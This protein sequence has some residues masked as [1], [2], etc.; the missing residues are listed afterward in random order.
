VELE[1]P[2]KSVHKVLILSGLR[3]FPNQAGGHLR[4]GN[5]AKALARLGYDV[6]IYS[7]AARRE[8]YGGGSQLLTQS[9][10]PGLVEEINL[11]LP[12][13]LAQT[14]ARRLGLPRLWQ[15]PI[16][17][18]GLIPA[19]LRDRLHWADFFI[20]DLPYVPPVPGP[21][22]KKPWVLLSHNLEFRLLEQGGFRD[23]H[24]FAPIL[25]EWERTA[26]KRYD[27]ILAC[28]TEDYDFFQAHNRESKPIQLVPNGIDAAL[29]APDAAVRAAVRQE[30]GLTA[31]DRVILFSGS[32]YAPNMEALVSLQDFV[33][34]HADALQAA[35]IKFLI[36]GSVAPASR[37]ARMIAT[38]FVPSVL[39]YFQ[40]ADF[41]INPVERGS[42]SNV[43]IFEYLAARLPILST[44]FGVRG[45]Q[46]QPERDYLPFTWDTLMSRLYNL[47]LVRSPEGWRSFGEE[48][49]QRHASSS[50]MTEI[51]RQQWEA[52][53]RSLPQLSLRLVSQVPQ[54]LTSRP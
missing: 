14:L 41:A 29:Y 38:G 10:E 35:S 17:A 24:L 4:S 49:W 15:Y 37:S 12:L 43:K 9:I 42:G 18:S 34:R 54:S 25:M 51:V 5:V 2:L 40:A 48:V 13:G 30:L 45:S 6:C 39:P 32:R 19:T 46:L 7:L 3:L 44:E 28:A 47:S 31:Q 26:S 21:W 36:L 22:R 8:D 11:A 33:K 16:L 27:G 53:E 20:C 23:R 50:D 52:L 1:G